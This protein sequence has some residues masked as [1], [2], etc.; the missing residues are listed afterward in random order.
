MAVPSVGQVARAR[1][2]KVT[3]KAQGREEV[4]DLDFLQLQLMLPLHH[5]LSLARVAKLGHRAKALKIDGVQVSQGEGGT[6]CAKGHPQQ[7]LHGTLRRWVL[8]LPTKFVHTYDVGWASSVS[9][10]E[11]RFF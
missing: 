2:E 9:K 6:P 10:T 11:S 7:V 1:R 3:P 8:G 5:Q 4:R